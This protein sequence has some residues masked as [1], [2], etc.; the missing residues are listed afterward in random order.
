LTDASAD[1]ARAVWILWNE[2]QLQRVLGV[3]RAILSVEE[4]FF[5]G[6]TGAVRYIAGKIIQP[7]AAPSYSMFA[8]Q[9]VEPKP[10]AILTA[11]A[12]YHGYWKY[13][14]PLN[15]TPLR[16]TAFK[17]RFTNET[18]TRWGV[19]MRHDLIV[20]GEN[21]GRPKTCQGWQGLGLRTGAGLN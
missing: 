17:E 6:E 10:G 20:H 21:D 9:E 5:S 12:A 3:A 19:G 4:S 11:S 1:E 15:L 14:Q 16:R 2:R 13:C 8:E 7:V 18:L